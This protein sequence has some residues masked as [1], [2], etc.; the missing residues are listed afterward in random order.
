MLIDKDIKYYKDV[1]KSIYKVSAILLKHQWVFKW[2]LIKVTW[3]SKGSRGTKVLL[4]SKK[5]GRG[6]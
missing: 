2:N 5:E 3:K 6:F 4:K 1:S